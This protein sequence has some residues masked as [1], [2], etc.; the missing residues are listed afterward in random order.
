YHLS[1]VMGTSTCDMLIAPVEEVKGKLV[2]GI[3]GQV[4]GSIIPGMMGMEAG[5]SAFGDVYAWFKNLLSWPLEQLQDE[6]LRT[7]LSDAVIV[8]LSDAA[9]KLP[10]QEKDELAIDWFNGRR[11]PDASQS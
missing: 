9:S 10:L 11:T 3:C 7:Q 2:K 6:Q 1:K 8:S 4:P 5:Q